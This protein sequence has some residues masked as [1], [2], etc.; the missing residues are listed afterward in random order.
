LQEEGW[1]VCRAFKKRTTS[2]S[3]SIEGWDSGYFYDEPSGVSS[4][5]DPIDFISRQPQNYLSQNFMCKQE[6]EADNLGGFMHSDQFVQLPQLASPSLPLIKR[7]A[8]SISRISENNEEELEQMNRVC[9]NN[10]KKVTDWR[11]LDKFVASQLSQEDRFDGDG[12]SSFGAHDRN[13]DMSLLLLQSSRVDDEEKLNG[14]LNSSSDCDIGI[15]IFE[16]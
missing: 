6:I 8:S 12:E 1:V 2:Q 14:F 15:C 7:P 3:K 4:V 13:S 5:V 10:S 9:N 11:A 16:K